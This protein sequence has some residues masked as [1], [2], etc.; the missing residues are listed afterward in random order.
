[1]TGFWGLLKSAWGRLLDQNR[2]A[3]TV[4]R[5]GDRVLCVQKSLIWSYLE[6]I[7]LLKACTYSYMY[8][9]DQSQIARPFLTK[10]FAAWPNYMVTHTVTVCIQRIAAC[11]IWFS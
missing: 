10:G 3:H 2:S 8:V 1:M 5:F 9:R 11:D 7:M 6:K 4:M